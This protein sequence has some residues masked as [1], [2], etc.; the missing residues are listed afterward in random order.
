MKIRTE[1]YGILPDGR[2]VTLYVLENDNGMQAEIINYGAALIRLLVP[3][4]QGICADIVLGHPS[5]EGYLTNSPYLG[6]LVG[7]SSNRIAGAA[8]TIAGTDYKLEANAGGNNLHSGLGGLSFRLLTGETKTDASQVSLQLSGTV[9]HL[10]DGFPGNLSVCVTYVLTSDNELQIRY[11]AVSDHDTVINLTNHSYFNLAGH[12][13]GTVYTQLLQIDAPF[14]TP[15]GSQLCP[16]GEIRSVAGSPFD[17]CSVKNIGR[18]IEQTD[19]GY[20]N[21][22]LL[23]GAGY[24]HIA[25]ASEPKSGRTMEVMTDL[26]A[27]QLYT[28]GSIG[29]IPGKDGA[30]YERH[31]GFCLE[32]QFVPNAVHMPWLTSPIFSAGQEFRS[33][34]AFRFTCK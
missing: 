13:S 20:D 22:L 15:L 1:R 14:Y 24:R 19:G 18:D 16:T 26:P 21:N 30:V 31:S 34:T 33:T 2:E 10:S 6:V 17:F 5:L 12:D 27:V 4:R 11:R 9:E 28:A 3:D 32:T 23:S 29:S 7:R 25:T 8:L